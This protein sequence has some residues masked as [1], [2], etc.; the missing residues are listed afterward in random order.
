MQSVSIT[1]SIIWRHPSW[2]RQMETFPAW[3]VFCEENPPVTDGDLMFTS[4]CAWTNGWVNNRNAGDLRRYHANYDVS[5]RCIQHDSACGSREIRAVTPIRV[6]WRIRKN[7][8]E[9]DGTA[10]YFHCRWVYLGKWPRQHCNDSSRVSWRLRL[11]AT[12]VL[13]QLFV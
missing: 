10:P 4:I 9:Y 12:R 11:P 3:L 1:W 8:R 2:H 5:V 13:V 7:G 6:N